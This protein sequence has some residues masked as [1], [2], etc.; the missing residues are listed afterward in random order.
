MTW[1]ATER[2]NQIRK[3]VLL[4]TQLCRLQPFHNVG[5]ERKRYHHLHHGKLPLLCQGKGTI[6][7]QCDFTPYHQAR[8]RT[9]QQQVAPSPPFG[10]SS[11]FYCP[12]R[13]RGWQQQ[14]H[15]ESIKILQESSRT[16]PYGLSSLEDSLQMAPGLGNHGNTVQDTA[17]IN[18]WV[19]NKCV[20][21]GTLIASFVR[22]V[23]L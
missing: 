13:G 8:E 18:T 7:L 5:G 1:A 23:S 6:V 4:A 3:D 11:S 22:H 16:V 19:T 2:D 21:K 17:G 10:H 12:A 20:V 14:Q 15:G 9:F